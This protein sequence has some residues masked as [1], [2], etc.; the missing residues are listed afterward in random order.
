MRLKMHIVG[1]SLPANIDTSHL[2]ICQI[3][4]VFVC[5]D[6]CAGM[7]YQW[8]IPVD[9]GMGVDGVAF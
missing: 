9:I 5:L 7:F 3:T 2:F 6:R 8:V 1:P 4:S